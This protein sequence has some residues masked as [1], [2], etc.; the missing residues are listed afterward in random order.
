MPIGWM[1]VID[2]NCFFLPFTKS[3]VS[4]RMEFFLPADFIDSYQDKRRTSADI[5]ESVLI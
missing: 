1:L 3:G 5:T 2:V 4:Q